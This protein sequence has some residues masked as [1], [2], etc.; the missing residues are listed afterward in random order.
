MGGQT[1]LLDH[2]GVH[3][4]CCLRLPSRFFGG[5]LCKSYV[6][7]WGK[8]MR[9]GASF[10][11]KKKNDEEMKKKKCSV[12]YYYHQNNNNNNTRQYGE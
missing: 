2:F 6:R 3:L 4:G 1:G 11:N 7:Y 9:G 8:E 10:K 5:V 12:Y